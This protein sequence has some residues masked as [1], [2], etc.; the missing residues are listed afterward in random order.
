MEKTFE[1][2]LSLTDKES[3]AISTNQNYI[4]LIKELLGN[5][6]KIIQEPSI[7]NTAPAILYAIK[8]GLEEF[9]WQED[10]VF[11]FFPS[12]HEIRPIEKFAESIEKAVKCAEEGYISL[13]GIEPTRPDTNYG[14]I[15]RGKPLKYGFI[16]EE[17]IEKPPLEKALS[18]IRENNFY[19]N[20]GIYIAKAG[21]L[22][23][24][25][26]KTS[27]EL[28]DFVKMNTE[29]LEKNFDKIPAISIDYALSER[30]KKLAVIP[31]N[32]FW[33]DVGS[34]EAIHELME[35]DE[36]GNVITGKVISLDTK[37]SFTYSPNEKLVITIGLNNMVVINTEDVLLIAEKGKTHLI[38]DVVK[39]LKEKGIKSAVEHKTIYRPWGHYQV[40]LE[41]ERF[42]VKKVF[43]KPGKRLSLQRHHHRAEHWVVVKG[44]AKITINDEERYIHENESVYVPKSALH[45]IENVGK[46]PLEIIEVQTG[47]Y[48]EEDDI[49]RIED[50]WKRK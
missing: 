7:K 9:Q 39:E 44:T 50:D 17:F 8:K 12:D 11:A 26:E 14:Y 28:K 20:S 13:L 47:E 23:E 15:K 40:L 48:V 37:N 36:K 38:K 2:T 29:E 6:V 33:S 32:F 30:S 16:A 10:D 4:F 43:V 22:L 31:A 1:R 27:P 25:L 3:I 49:E 19:W 41:G 21:I 35:K 24:E 18:M 46:I 34:W 42:K 5:D 45:R